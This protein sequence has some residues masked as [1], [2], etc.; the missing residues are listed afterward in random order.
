MPE[1]R[2]LTRMPVYDLETGR[3]IGRVRRLIV[4]PEARAVAGLLINGRLGKGVPCIPFRGLHAIGQ[5]AVT[6]RSAGALAPLSEHAD[7]QELLRSRRRLYHTPI[8]TEGGKFLG[9]VDEF[10]IDP[11]SGRIETLLLSGG[12]IRDLFRGQAVLPAHLVLTI[13]EDVVIVRDEAVPLLELRAVGAGDAGPYRHTKDRPSAQ[14]TGDSAG[15]R[16]VLAI[17]RRWRTCRE[18]P[19]QGTLP[20]RP[21]PGIGTADEPV[22][23]HL[24]EAAGG[25]SPN[26][27]PSAGGAGSR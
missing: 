15:R 14:S 21:V 23:P 11:K 10:T 8:L 2:S 16:P 25:A 27:A 26:E 13:G 24:E 20:A 6:V 19:D 5:H 7:L 4:D 18:V 1:S 3:I 9:D 17:W 12:L 22:S